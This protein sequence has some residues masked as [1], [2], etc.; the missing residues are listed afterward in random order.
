MLAVTSCVIHHTKTKGPDLTVIQFGVPGGVMVNTYKETATVT[1]IDPATR[2]VTLVKTDGTQDT[3]IAGPEVANFAQIEV[4]DQVKATVTDKLLMFV[5]K[6]GESSSGGAATA[7]ALAPLG[8][9]PGG[10]MADTVEFT[11]KVTAVSLWHH[12]ATLQF[13]DGSSKTFD[14]RPDVTLTKE[15]VGTEVVIRTTEAV[16]VSVEKP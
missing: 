4:G 1:A 14:V 16:A 12:T 3:F 7:V 6:P 5:P 9:K 15:T 2:K 11:A 13:P 8:E 10:V